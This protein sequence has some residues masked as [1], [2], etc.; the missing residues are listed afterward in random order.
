[1]PNRTAGRNPKEKS[2][3]IA[4]AL[5]RSGGGEPVVPAP[6]PGALIE[7]A[8]D[9]ILVWDLEETVLLWNAG[10]T[11]LLGWSG[12][13]ARGRKV[14]DLVIPDPALLAEARQRV[15]AQGAWEF[16]A[17]AVSQD[18][19]KVPL[20]CHLTL[21]RDPAGVPRWVLAI[22]HD[23]SQKRRVEEQF[24]RAQRLESIGLL[25]G[26]IAHD[27]NNALGPI[28]MGCDLLAMQ[29]EGDAEMR[30]VLETMQTSAQRGAALIQQVLGVAR[31]V[32][33][34]QLDI[35]PRHLL[36]EV[37]RIAGETFPKSITVDPQVG[38]DLWPLLG[39][40]GQIHQVLLNLAVNARDA[41]PAG[42]VLTLTG[43]NAVLDDAF[44][45]RHPEAKSGPHVVLEI[46]DTGVGIP[47]K[48]LPRIFDPFF[49]T[50]DPSQHSG[51]GLSTSRAI[52][53][54]H[55]GFIQIDTAVGK[56]TRVLVHLPARPPQEPEP[57]RLLTTRL[58]RGAGETILVVDD[59]ASAREITRQ[60][61][62]AFGYEVLTAGDGAEAVAIFARQNAEI[63]LV[64]LDLLMPVMDGA[65]TLQVLRRLRPD[66]RVIIASGADDPVPAKD[67]V[68][69]LHK[70]FTAET[71]LAALEAGL[72]GPEA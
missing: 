25:A 5:P 30:E 53:K 48:V 34:E 51:L 6:E 58:P 9:P 32:H 8:H 20:E 68:T 72:H 52:T 71:L 29:H 61:L 4:G 54:S 64:L 69:H 13:E 43:R 23:V 27:L 49:S 36:K 2:P 55:G 35:Q 28:L 17:T 14:A 40:P 57:V 39:D 31:G 44:V 59:E 33:G 38:D 16:E 18:Q 15:F 47:A 42:G 26:G 45:A 1:M 22:L 67:V 60:T 19:R 50:K 41:M 10:A 56:G 70:P 24:L 7:Q 3:D 11:R 21:I 62:R 63:S 12:A 37:A 46:A 65:A 66:V